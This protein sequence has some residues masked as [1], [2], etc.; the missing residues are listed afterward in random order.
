MS[1]PKYLED[2][3]PNIYLDK[4]YLVLDV[5]TTN[6]NYGDPHDA[7]NSLLY[8]SCCTSS[9]VYLRGV[10]N[11]Y[12]QDAL[13]EACESATFIVAHNAKF[14]LGWLKRCGAK[15]DRILVFDTM[16]A[17]YVLAGNTPVPLDLDSVAKRRGIGHKSSY[18]SKMIKSGYP[19]EDVPSSWLQEYCDQDVALTHAV[20]QQQLV[21]LAERNLLP[22]F[23]T[24][25]IFTP[26]LMEIE[27][28]GM[29]LD[30]DR[31]MQE[32]N[33]V[34]TRF[35]EVDRELTEYTGGIN[36]NSPKQVAEFLYDTLGFD[37]LRDQRGNTL[38]TTADGR[39]TDAATIAALKVNTKRQGRFIELYKERNSL[40]T[41]LS[42]YLTKFKE[43]CENDN[44]I[45][46]ANFNQ[47][48]TRTHRLSSSGKIYKMQFQNFDRDYKPLFKARYKDWGIG[49][50]DG[51]QLEFRV[52]AFLGQDARAIE[53]IRNGFDVHAFTALTLTEAGQPTDRQ[54][55][56]SHTFKPLYGGS[57]G[58]KAEQRYYQ[59]FKDKYPGITGA[60]EAWKQAVLSTKQ[61]VTCTGLIFYWPD[62]HMTRSGYI[63]NT[64]SICNYPVQMFATADI[65]PIAVTYMY[66]RMQDKKL[67]SF[68][69]NTVHDSAISEVHPDEKD[70]MKELYEYTF[71]TDVYE[72]LRAVYNIEF[73][74][75]LKADVKFSTHWGGK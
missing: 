14:E 16:I 52:A 48:R 36:A 7:V 73:N 69:V 12:K 67:Q 18:V 44:G 21:E 60:Q 64:T 47:C 54:G 10:G 65:I 11:E 71:T 40:D 26:V 32:Y 13:V 55:A 62:T 42:K 34:S 23:F 6:K 28:R 51:A 72:Y 43:C 4:N 75:P 30:Y 29:Q 3:N 35:L 33:Q 17:E 58:S 2:C 15:A 74:V 39:K 50:G 45:L 70:V 56:K 57:S 66:Y 24:R 49:E 31:V 63:T 53:D 19:P 20:M 59:A 9:D 8:S 27:G 46:Y 22:V 1:L 61:L 41:S 5:E 25:C 38:R 37:E 68:L